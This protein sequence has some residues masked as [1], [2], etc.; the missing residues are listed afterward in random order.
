MI[1]HVS[2]ASLVALVAGCSVPPG[3]IAPATLPEPATSYE[4]AG[5]SFSAPARGTLR[6]KGDDAEVVYSDGHA[7]L[8]VAAVPAGGGQISESSIESALHR[9][10]TL[11]GRPLLKEESPGVGIFCME[12]EPPSKVA[13][14][15]RLDEDSRRGGSI[16]LTT[17]FADAQT[18]VALGGVRAPAEAARTAKGFQA[19]QLP[20]VR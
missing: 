4:D 6:W 8:T 16:V 13:A 17:F 14:C 15:A 3:P 10:L 5:R 19:T 9:I 11:D 2:L 1:A 20:A 18:Y 12:S 7:K